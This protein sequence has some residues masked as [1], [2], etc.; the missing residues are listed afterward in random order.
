MAR[1]YVILMIIA[2]FAI[3]QTGTIAR[4]AP[5]ENNHATVTDQKTFGSFGGFTGNDGGSNPASGGFPGS[6]S[7]GIP[8]WGF[9]G[10]PGL[11]GDFGQ[12]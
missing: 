7:S 2:L 9:P 1:W 4:N 3:I 6:G 11:S 5:T 8:N 10:I 12:P